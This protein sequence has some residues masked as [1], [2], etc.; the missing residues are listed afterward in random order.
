VAGILTA[1]APSIAGQ[2]TDLRSGVEDGVRQATD[3]LA[4]EP[5]D[6][7]QSDIDDA[8]D[9]A[10]KELRANSGTITRGVTTGAVVVGEILTGLII[11]ILLTFFFLKDGRG[12]WRWFVWLV[13]R[14]RKE[15]LHELGVKVFTALSGYIRGIAL[16]GIA[17]ALLI[18]LGLLIIGVPLVI[19]LMV[20]TF[21]G[22]FIPLIGAFLAG[23]AAVL[24]ALVSNGFVAALLVLGVIILVQQVEGHLLYPI[25]MSRSVHLHP[26]VIVV[27]LAA[28]GVIAGIIGVFLAV[29]V[30]AAAS[31]TIRHVKG[32]PPP[33]GEAPPD[34][35]EAVADD[36]DDPEADHPPLAS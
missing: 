30:A 9:N 16:V 2:V 35:D 36:P 5:F 25:L 15:D 23:L 34:P 31:V 10:I 17:D 3:V 32:T 12:L 14:D 24:I 26:A 19:P 4:K 20:L 27:A 22:A 33:M 29:P 1:I 8:V 7:S 13:G 21:F 11:T 6:L 18:G 28:G